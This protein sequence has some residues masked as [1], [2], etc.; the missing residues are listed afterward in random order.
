M[1][2]ELMAAGII[3]ATS[4]DWEV[5]DGVFEG[6]A[7]CGISQTYGDGTNFL[8]AVEQK[9][10]ERNQFSFMASNKSWSIKEG[11]RIGDITVTTE[12]LSFGSIARTG[13]GLFII[14]S[15]LDGLI[16]VL[17]SAANSPIVIIISE[18]KKV[19]GAYSTASL[20]P[21]ADKLEAC[22]RRRFGKSDDPFAK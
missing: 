16:P 4:K 3:A 14:G 7:I 9:D 8:F 21:A 13:P 17:R 2:L 15:F 20:Q 5:L 22:V 10:A 11:E 6:G 12:S 1:L 19:V 18:R